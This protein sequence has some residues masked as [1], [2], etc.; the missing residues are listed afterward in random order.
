MTFTRVVLADDHA[1]VRL[2][3]RIIL[4]RAPDV[5]VVGEANNGLEALRLVEELTPDVLLLDMEMPGL[6]GV[7]VAQR[8]KA[9]DSSVRILALSSYDDKQYILGLLATGA[10]GYLVKEEAPENIVAAVRGVARGERGWVSQR[11]AMQ[12][13]S[14]NQQE[15]DSGSVKTAGNNL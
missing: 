9:A 11:V 13:A 10:S 7:E 8:L 2:G 4:E 1:A 5:T 3:I 6:K 12:I 14:W 15:K